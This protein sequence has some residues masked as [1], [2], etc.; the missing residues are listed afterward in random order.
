MLPMMEEV[1][2]VEELG[3]VV[4]MVVEEVEEGEE[5]EEMLAF[6]FSAT[7]AE[8]EA[9]MLANAPTIIE[10]IVAA[11]REITLGVVV[12]AVAVVVVAEIKVVVVEVRVW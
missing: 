11:E 8:A 5:E 9:I 12:V 1:G 3:I 6:P 4:E 10:M 2:E 7:L